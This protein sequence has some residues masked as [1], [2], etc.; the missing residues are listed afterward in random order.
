VSRADSVLVQDIRLPGG[1]ALWLRDLLSKALDQERPSRITLHPLPQPD[2]VC[3]LPCPIPGKSWTQVTREWRGS[4]SGATDLK[5]FVKSRYGVT[6]SV[7]SLR[8]AANGAPVPQDLEALG[9]HLNE[10]A[11]FRSRTMDDSSN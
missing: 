2:V 1:E 3:Y 9:A 4:R 8:K 11:V 10:V 5:G 7:R 6:F